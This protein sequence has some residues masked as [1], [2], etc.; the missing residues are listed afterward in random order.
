MGTI[1]GVVMVMEIAM[2]MYIGI[3][4]FGLMPGESTLNTFSFLSL[5]FFAIFSLFVVRQDGHFWQSKP[6]TMLGGVIAADTII[7]SMIGVFG[8][9]DLPGIGWPILLFI[10]VYSLLFS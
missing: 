10:V 3:H 8:V 5:F 7:A 1:L 2:L 6:S 4:Y 9:S